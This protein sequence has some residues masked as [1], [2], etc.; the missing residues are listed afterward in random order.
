[1]HRGLPR[2]QAFANSTAKLTITWRG[3]TGP[4]AI[5]ISPG[6]AGT[7]AGGF[8]ILAIA[9]AAIGGYFIFKD[10]LLRSAIASQARMQYAYEDRISQLRAHVDRVVSRQLIDQDTVESKLHELISRQVQLESRQVL[11]AR[12]ADDAQR[13]GVRAPAVDPLPTGASAFGQTGPTGLGG[14]GPMPSLF[15]PTT[16][17]QPLPDAAT[18]RTPQPLDELRTNRLSAA[19][20]V[21][22]ATAALDRRALPAMLDRADAAA[23]SLA[24]RQV[25]VLGSLERS[26]AE[27]SKRLRGALEATGLNPKRFADSLARPASVEA[28]MGGPLVASTKRDSAA[29]ER[30]LTAAQTH[31]ADSERYGRVLK[32]LPI[33]RPLPSEHETT[34]GFGT[35]IDP[36]TRG[37]AQHTGLDFRATTGTPIRATAEGKVVEAGWVGGYGRMVEIDHGHGI[38]SRYGHMSAISVSTGDTVKRGQTVGLVGSSGRSTGPHLHYEVRIDDDAADPMAFLKAGERARAN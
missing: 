31:L 5:E 26:A 35:R 4:R 9:Y 24:A 33:R 19:P 27:S 16:R 17:P 3:R 12:L 8:G 30:A 18:I 20:P 2:A 23:T 38:T 34:S 21:A 22:P 15:Q 11:V 1:M 25:S 29:F 7:I 37:Y 10:D 14:P 36:F 28:P 32:S 6:M 13:I